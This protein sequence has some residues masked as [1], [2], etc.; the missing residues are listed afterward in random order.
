MREKEL[1]GC[2]GRDGGNTSMSQEMPS[3]ASDQQVLER[4]WGLELLRELGPA[5]KLGF[6]LSQLPAP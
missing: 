1:H 4:G 5:I 2:G 6:Q 3:I